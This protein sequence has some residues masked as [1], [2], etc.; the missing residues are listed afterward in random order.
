M[1]PSVF[2]VSL[3]WLI[4]AALFVIYWNSIRP[5][6]LPRWEDGARRVERDRGLTNRPITEGADNLAAGHADP[7]TTRL[8]QT[9][10]LR[11]LASVK[12]LR[13]RLPSPKLHRL[14]PYGTRFVLLAALIAAFFFA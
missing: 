14:D 11:L 6:R 5:I 10:V 1:L 2:R 3:L 12:S 13:V 4:G 9:H 8:W 7:L